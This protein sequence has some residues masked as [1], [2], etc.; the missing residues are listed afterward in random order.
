MTN[1]MIVD[2]EL[3]AEIA[4]EAG[5]EIGCLEWGLE[6]LLETGTDE[7]EAY[8]KW[9]QGIESGE[10]ECHCEEQGEEE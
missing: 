3:E 6:V 5:H 10:A 2:H 4:A 7:H 1:T 9:I 8:A